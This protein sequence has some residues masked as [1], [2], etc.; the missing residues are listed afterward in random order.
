MMIHLWNP[1]PKT[2][3]LFLD[4]SGDETSRK[5]MEHHTCL[6]DWSV[7]PSTWWRTTHGSFLWVSSPQL[8]QW[9]N[10]LLIP[11]KSLGLQL[12]Y[13]PWDEPPSNSGHW[14]FL[15]PRHPC[16]RRQPSLP[17]RFR[18][19]EA[20]CRRP[21]SNPMIRENVEVW[22]GKSRKIKGKP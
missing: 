16:R 7:D 8:F 20:S 17:M 14:R 11:C 6:M 10:P 12:T 5:I 22:A 2:G 19:R 15:H 9:I 4:V 18:R 13:E 1:K 3:A 21:G